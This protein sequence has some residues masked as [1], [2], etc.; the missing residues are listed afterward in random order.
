MYLSTNKERKM[1]TELFGIKVTFTDG[2]SIINTNLGVTPLDAEK[3]A[4]SFR[5]GWMGS[6]IEKIETITFN[7]LN[8][9]FVKLEEKRQPWERKD[10]T[11]NTKVWADWHGEDN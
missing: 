6:P 8:W 10:G 3:N 9:D 5:E 7:V 2:R 1:I 11:I 4:V